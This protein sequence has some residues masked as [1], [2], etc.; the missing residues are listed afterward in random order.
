VRASIEQSIVG[1]ERERKEAEERQALVNHSISELEELIAD[2]G[3][4]FACYRGRIVDPLRKGENELK[5]GLA[6]LVSSL[7]LKETSIK[8][9]L[10][11]VNRTGL[12]SSVFVPA[13]PDR[14]ELPT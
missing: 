5:S 1:L 12:R 4:L 13:P 7:V 3:D 10:A 9:A 11:G 14:L 2:D 8:I 6:E